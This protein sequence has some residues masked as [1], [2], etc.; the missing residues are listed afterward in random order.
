MRDKFVLK[1]I[2]SDNPGIY[3]TTYGNFSPLGSF[4]NTDVYIASDLRD[5]VADVIC[6]IVTTKFNVWNC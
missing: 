6:Y 5:T 3:F 2:G 1:E 4:K